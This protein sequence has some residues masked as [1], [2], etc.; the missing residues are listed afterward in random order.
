MGSGK[1]TIGK[2]L[3]K[4]LG[5]KFF[6][7]DKVIEKNAGVT[8]P[9]IFDVEGESGFRQREQAVIEQLTAK[10]GIV[11]A[12]GGGAV[13]TASNRSH[14]A[15]RGTVV[16]LKVSVAEQLVRLQKTRNRPLLMTDN[17]KQRLFALNTEREPLYLEVADYICQT[18]ARSVAEITQEI[19]ANMNF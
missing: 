11:L 15:A 2:S 19:L 1:T 17:R 6:D 4:A 5:L 3:A 14:L 9:W 8:I 12:T 10:Q 18:D 16:Y 7:S 13:I